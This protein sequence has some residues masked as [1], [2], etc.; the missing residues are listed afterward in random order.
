MTKTVGRVR[1]R[2]YWPGQHGVVEDWIQCCEWYSTGKARKAGPRAP[3]VSCLPGYPI[4]RVAIDILGPLPETER[5]ST[6]STSWWSPTISVNG[7]RVILYPTKRRG[8]WH[9]SLWTSL[10]VDLAPHKLSIQTK[11]ATLSPPCSRKCVTYL[12]WKRPGPPRIIPRETA[13]LSDS[14]VR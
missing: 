1:E 5:K 10:S 13:W 2:F 8:Q 7:Q 4:E 12:V 3:L 14:T 9:R 6:T 11:A